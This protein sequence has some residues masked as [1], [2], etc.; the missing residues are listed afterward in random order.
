MPSLSPLQNI[1][2]YLHGR[3]EGHRLV[4][5]YLAVKLLAVEKV[6]QELLDLRDSRGPA[7]KHHLIYVRLRQT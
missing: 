2:A 7:D 6:R 4:W 5:V 1:S 3:S